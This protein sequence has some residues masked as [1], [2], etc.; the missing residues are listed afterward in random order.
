VN[1]EFFWCKWFILRDHLIRK[2]QL[3]MLKNT[4]N[5]VIK[6][7]IVFILTMSYSNCLFK[8]LCDVAGICQNKMKYQLNEQ[9]E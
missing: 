9:A 7:I 1:V 4:Q 6:I 3:R 8:K 5:E 2:G